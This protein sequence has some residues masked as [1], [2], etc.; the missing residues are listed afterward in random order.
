[1]GV[2][3]LLSMVPGHGTC[4]ASCVIQR[5][6]EGFDDLSINISCSL[7]EGWR[8]SRKAFL[9]MTMYVEETNSTFDGHIG[10]QG[11]ERGYLSD[12]L[13]KVDPE[14]THYII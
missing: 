4:T 8:E 11:Q 3:I 6:P 12:P 10:R 7:D 9:H 2:K 5:V 13:E 14:L 1:M